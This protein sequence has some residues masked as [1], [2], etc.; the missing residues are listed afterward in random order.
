MPK[1]LRTD[2]ATRCATQFAS[3][4][5][6]AARAVAPLEWTFDLSLWV[7][8]PPPP[9][10]FL[11]ELAREALGDEADM[12]Q[13]EPEF[14]NAFVVDGRSSR[15]YRFVYSSD[16]LSLSRERALEAHQK[17]GDHISA[18]STPITLRGSGPVHAGPPP[19]GDPAS[20]EL[21]AVE[22]AGAYRRELGVRRRRMK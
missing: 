9:D 20:A 12:L 16:H 2:D 15:T 6:T 19:P 3:A 5:S 11:L 22:E 13:R 17:I 4:A 10:A 18:S 14:L 1:W 21:T 7:E 8:L